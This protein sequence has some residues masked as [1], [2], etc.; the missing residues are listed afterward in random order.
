MFVRWTAIGGRKGEEGKERKAKGRRRKGKQK[1]GEGKERKLNSSA[2]THLSFAALWP[3]RIPEAKD[4]AYW[5]TPFD[6]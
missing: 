6:F 1:R 3:L 2:D 4:P 5:S